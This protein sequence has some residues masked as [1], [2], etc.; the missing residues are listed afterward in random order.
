MRI[1]IIMSAIAASS[2]RLPPPHVDMSGVRRLRNARLRFGLTG[3][4]DIHHIVPRQ[5]ASRIPLDMMHSADNLIF[6]PNRKGSATLRLRGA[7]VV[8]DGGHEA[9]NEHVNARLAGI[10][11]DDRQAIRRLQFEL[12]ARIRS[13][14][15]ALP[16]RRGMPPPPLR[17]KKY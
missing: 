5:F 14:D 3:L 2:G 7:R 8:H 17:A 16:W 13:A 15:P 6:I 12:R 1:A 11:L 4:V 9:Y 10:A